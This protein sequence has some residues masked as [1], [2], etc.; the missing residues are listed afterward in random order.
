MSE[1]IELFANS[2]D[3]IREYRAPKDALLGARV[4][5]AWYG[6]LDYAG[7]SLVIFEKDGVLY[8]V[9]GSHCSC[10]DLEGQWEPEETSWAALYVRKIPGPNAYF[11]GEEEANTLLQRLVA[12]HYEPPAR[13]R[14]KKGR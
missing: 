13:M 1:Y 3:V 7:S 5:L 14:S 11:D 6:Y 8:E 9:N 4:W 2:D 12:E 10:D